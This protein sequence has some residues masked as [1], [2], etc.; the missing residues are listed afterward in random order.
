MLYNSD[1]ED[2][3]VTSLVGIVNL[4]RPRL[5]RSV[6]RASKLSVLK[7]IEIVIL[8]VYY[9]IPFGLNLFRH[10]L[11]ITFLLFELLCLAKDHWRRFSARNAHMVYIVKYIWFK[12]VYVHLGGS[13]FL[14]WDHT[15]D[16]LLARTHWY[17]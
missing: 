7:L 10:I 3:A 12:M 5:I 15:K 14:Y 2:T 8:K 16:P 17:N 13:L 1:F 9:T 11:G 6:L 4:S